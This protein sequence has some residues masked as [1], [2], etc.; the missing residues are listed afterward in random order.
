MGQEGWGTRR[1]ATRSESPLL[2]PLVAPEPI[3][4]PNLPQQPDEATRCHPARNWRGQQPRRRRDLVRGFD[5][6]RLLDRRGRRGRAG[7]HR[8]SWLW[9]IALI[10]RSPSPTKARSP[11]CACIVGVGY[12]AQ[13]V[14]IVRMYCMTVWTV[15]F[16]SSL[17][18]WRHD[19]YCPCA[20][21]AVADGPAQILATKPMTPCSPGYRS[22]CPRTEASAPSPA[23]SSRNYL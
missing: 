15:L 21:D 19:D 10:T 22:G 20:S 2:C 12:K 8:G 17:I 18:A 16:G 13:R 14:C 7:E 11:C 5:A 4:T 23:K 9:P 3:T 1:S 6:G